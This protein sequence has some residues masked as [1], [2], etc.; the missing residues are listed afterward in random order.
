MRR[1]YTFTL[2]FNKLTKRFL[3]RGIWGVRGGRRCLLFLNDHRVWPLS[4]AADRC[5]NRLKLRIYKQ[6]VPKSVSN[7]VSAH[8]RLPRQTMIGKKS[9][10]FSATTCGVSTPLC[11]AADE[12]DRALFFST[13]KYIFTKDESCRWSLEVFRPHGNGTTCT[14]VVVP[15]PGKRLAYIYENTYYV[16]PLKPTIL[17]ITVVHPSRFL[18]SSLSQR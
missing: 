14:T 4:K 10:L 3:E 17:H 9:A 13:S 16:G 1:G 15:A 18:P 2:L 11:S 7:S 8:T 12:F 5:C 6:L